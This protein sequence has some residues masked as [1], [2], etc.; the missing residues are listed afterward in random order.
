[1]LGMRKA[2]KALGMTQKD[3]ADK[4]G[5]RE[6]YISRWETGL[7]SPSIDTLKRIAVVLGVTL[8]ELVE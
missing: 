5:V 3:L 7:V 6:L 4:I 2:R 1:M 8:D